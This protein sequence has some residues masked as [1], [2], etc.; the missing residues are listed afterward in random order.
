[1]DIN[2]LQHAIGVATD[3]RWGPV[4]RAALVVRFTNPQAP[5]ITPEQLA[6]IAADLGCTVRQINAVASVESSGGGFDKTGKPKILFERHLFH[7]LTGGRY[8]PAPYS[9]AAGGGYDEPSWSKLAYAAGRDPD[10]AF[11]ACS[12]GKFQVLGTHWSK[13]GYASAYELAFSTVQSEAAHYELLSRYVRTFGLADE[14]RAV[15]ADPETCRGF[16]AGYNG[17]GYRN[18]KYHT[19]IAEAFA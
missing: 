15:S 9:N 11:S 5:A 6:A 10:A 1:M 3:G 7:R 19:R 13:L 18:F 14:L 12:W 8:S 2:E 4:S 17:P 16:A